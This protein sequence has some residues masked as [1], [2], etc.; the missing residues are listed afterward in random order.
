L[1]TEQLRQK[2]NSFLR[3]YGNERNARLFIYYAGHG[4]TEEILERNENRGYITGIDTP[5]H[6]GTAAGYNAARP[7]AISMP[8]I[9]GP[10]ATVLAQHILVVFD[11]CFAGTIFTT[12]AGDEP[13]RNLTPDEVTRLFERSSR[14]FITTG[15][16]NERVP[17]HSPLPELFLAALNGEADRYQQGVISAADIGAF[18]RA[19]IRDLREFNLTPQQGRLPDPAFAEGAFL[20]RVI[21]QTGVSPPAAR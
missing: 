17:A 14:E 2:I 1:E 7:L 11:S 3:S 6:R 16:A 20:F 19:R 21:K 9:K 4:Y 5:W 10:V 12:R 8:E 13:P 15:S 18:L